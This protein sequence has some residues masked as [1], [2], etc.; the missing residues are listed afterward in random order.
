MVDRLDYK[1]V[2]LAAL[3]L[4]CWMGYCP[5]AIRGALVWSDDFNDGNYDGWT[6]CENPAISSG[7]N[8]SAI[9]NYLQLDQEDL[10]KISHPSN[11]AYGKWSFDFKVNETQLVAEVPA[12]ITFIGEKDINDVIEVD[13]FDDARGYRFDFRVAYTSEGKKLSLSLRKWHGGVDTTID[14]SETLLSLADWHH[15]EVTRTT[16]GLFSVYHNGSLVMEG[17]D[18]EIDAS[19]RRGK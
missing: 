9:N 10:G 7:S 14:T 3:I 19:V 5:S 2:G 4:L 17:V 12:K 1:V 15:I 18:T 8:W 6:I 13:G 11:I 16:A